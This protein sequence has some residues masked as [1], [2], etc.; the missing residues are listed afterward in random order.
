MIFFIF[1][2]KLAFPQKTFHDVPEIKYGDLNQEP[3]F[4]KTNSNSQNELNGRS[5]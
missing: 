1:K 3:P 4:L 2:T 5:I